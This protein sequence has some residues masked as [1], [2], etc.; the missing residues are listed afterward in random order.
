MCISSNKNFMS[1]IQKSDPNE[2]ECFGDVLSRFLL[3]E[4]LGYDDILMSS[5]KNLA[6]QEDNK[7]MCVWYDFINGVL[8]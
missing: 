6:E 8:S 2:D 7:G 3:E 1:I 4:F 5:V